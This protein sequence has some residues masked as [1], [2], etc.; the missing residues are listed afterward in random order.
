M[1]ADY[2]DL[3]IAQIRPRL[4][5]IAEVA[6]VLRVSKTTIYR[7]IQVGDLPAVHIADATV[8]VRM[9]DLEKYILEHAQ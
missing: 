4:L 8:R 2:A 7:L 6:D 5:K 3:Q 9:V 1:T